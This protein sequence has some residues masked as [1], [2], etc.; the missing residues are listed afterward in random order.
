VFLKQ[1]RAARLRASLTVVDGWVYFIHGW[2]RVIAEVFDI[3]T[4]GAIFD[5][6]SRI[7]LDA[8]NRS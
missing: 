1:A 6:L 5:R 2:T 7:A 3:P 8:A 4:S